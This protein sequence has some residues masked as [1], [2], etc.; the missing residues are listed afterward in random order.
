MNHLID[1][2]REVTAK[3]QKELE[4]GRRSSRVDANDIVEVLLAIADEAERLDQ[5]AEAPCPDCGTLPSNFEREA[6][7]CGRCGR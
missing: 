1:A 6:A 5:A 2:I 4:S 3:V 7:P